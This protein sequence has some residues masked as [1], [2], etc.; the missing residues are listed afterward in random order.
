MSCHFSPQGHSAH[1]QYQPGLGYVWDV[2][3]HRPC[4]SSAFYVLSPISDALCQKPPHLS[5]SFL[6]VTPLLKPFWVFPHLP[7][8][9]NGIFNGGG[10]PGRGS[11]P[12]RWRFY[13]HTPLSPHQRFVLGCIHCQPSFMVL[14]GYGYVPAN[15]SC[16]LL[17]Q[18]STGLS[19]PLG[20]CDGLH[21]FQG[22]TPVAGCL[23]TITVF[24]QLY[25]WRTPSTA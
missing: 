4:P 12:R 2:G 22:C 10:I 13:L 17:L 7:H 9:R 6:N 5:R 20:V 3:T 21:P 8:Q 11:C 16:S 24:P 18:L 25:P 23:F 1:H 14:R 19:G 15:P